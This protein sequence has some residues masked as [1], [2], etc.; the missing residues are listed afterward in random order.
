MEILYT[1]NKKYIPKCPKCSK[2]VKFKINYE[3]LDISVECIKGHNIKNLPFETFNNKYIKPSITYI[4]NC[5]QCF[6]NLENNT[7]IY[8][9]QT[10][11]KLYC[12]NC[13]DKHKKDTKHDS[14]IDFIQQNQLCKTHNKKYYYF[15]ENCKINFCNTCKKLHEGHDIKS[16]LDVIPN[17]KEKNSIDSK[18]K[19]FNKKIEDTKSIINKYKNEIIKRYNRIKDF[20][21]FLVDL[22]KKLLINFNN[23]YLDY[24]NF[25]NYKYLLNS[26]DNNNSSDSTKY[27]NYLTVK[28]GKIDNK[29]FKHKDKIIK[30]I[31]FIE[32][33]Q[34]LKYLKEDIFFVQ[35]NNYIKFFEFKNFSFNHILSYKLEKLPIYNVKAAKYN[36][37]IFLNLYHKTI[38][39]LEYN[40]NKKSIKLSNKK[41]IDYDII[42][43]GQ[44]S[45]Y[46]DLKNGN[47]ITLYY[48][49]VIIWKNQ[50]NDD[51][52]TK[53]LTINIIS[54][55]VYEINSNFFF[56]QDNHYNI[57]FYDVETFECQN[58]I[59]YKY[60]IKYIGMINDELAIFKKDSIENYMIIINIKYLEIVQF[61]SGEFNS[62][63]SILKKN[64]FFDFNIKNQK[65]FINK[66]IISI[67]NGYINNEKSINKSTNLERVNQIIVTDKGYA[68][69][70]DLYNFTFIDLN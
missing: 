22:N 32:N 52:M 10:C 46:F 26:L 31:E 58:I 17:I 62:E 55:T 53:A 42:S 44:F 41:I 67:K 11:N 12:Q 24:Y 49:K 63:S 66:R 16:F 23:I 20:L 1:N 40:L 50:T 56:L 68:V 4:C 35:E 13:L 43:S 47:V 37:Y 69:L 6:N 19:V 34:L 2:I 15:C 25:E 48:D 29:N 61:I 7:N 28:D 21:S 38:L 18:L 5:S 70:C 3:T 14:I 54:D 59:K 45:K 9:C 64:Y 51:F 57:K 60:N 36:N 27:L 39:F 30:N 8:K 65:L 33:P